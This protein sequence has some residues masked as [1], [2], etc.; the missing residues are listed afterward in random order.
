MVTRCGAWVA[1]A[2]GAVAQVKR[3]GEPWVS[4]FFNDRLLT[5]CVSMRP[6]PAESPRLCFIRIDRK[7]VVVASA[8]VG[9]MID[10]ATDRSPAQVSKRSKTSGACTPMVGCSAEGGLQ[11]RKRTPATYSPGMPVGLQRQHAAVAADARG[12]CRSCRAAA[13]AGARPMNRRSAPCRCGRPLRPAHSRV[14]WPGAVRARCLRRPRCRSAGNG[15]R[16]TA[17]TSA[18]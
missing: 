15:T 7:G 13:P 18:F 11:A 17:R 3:G 6:E 8:R 14:R 12:A 9:N 10:A 2:P 1:S 5:G 4:R 16:R